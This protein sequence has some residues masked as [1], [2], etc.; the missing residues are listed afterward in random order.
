MAKKVMVALDDSTESFYA[1][2][3]A[4]QHVISSPLNAK[5]DDIGKL[6]DIVVLI[7]AQEQEKFNAVT[8]GYYLKPA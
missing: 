4:L 7:H 2:E 8:P 6:S 3:W 5:S 1:L